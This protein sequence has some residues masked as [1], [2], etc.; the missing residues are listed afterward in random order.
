MDENAPL[1]ESGVD[2]YMAVHR[3]ARGDGE[4]VRRRGAGALPAA[5]LAAGLHRDGGGLVRIAAIPA[6]RFARS[7]RRR[8]AGGPL[9]QSPGPP[10]PP[11]KF[12]PGGFPHAA[13]PP[14]RVSS[15]KISS[16][17][18]PNSL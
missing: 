8:F 14:A 16:P 17:P 12:G 7:R 15:A 11:E 10:F 6:P 1:S 18:P 3:R 13:F 9:F 2:G 4:P 5:R